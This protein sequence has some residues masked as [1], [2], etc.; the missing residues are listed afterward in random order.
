MILKRFHPASGNR[1]A[2]QGRTGI[3]TEGRS[4]Y[5]AEVPCFRR[6]KSCSLG[7]PAI[8]YRL[9][10]AILP[11]VGGAA[12]RN[13]SPKTTASRMP[14]KETQT[15][16]AR[17]SDEECHNRPED[18]IRTFITECTAEFV[19]DSDQLVGV[20]GCEESED[21][22]FVFSAEICP[23]PHMAN[24]GARNRWGQ[25]L[26]KTMAPATIRVEF[27]LT[28]VLLFHTGSFRRR[29]GIGTGRL[30]RR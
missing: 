9:F 22:L 5:R 23:H 18:S 8:G 16:T 1:Y 7:R 29:F 28:H 15:E 30:R 21:I 11:L 10:G 26:R 27:A 14:H 19:P 6:R 12:G 4:R 3:T 24:H 20:L 13:L 25:L 17:P 2:S